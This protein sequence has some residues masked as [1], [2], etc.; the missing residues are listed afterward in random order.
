MTKLT[1]SIYYFFK[2]NRLVFWATLILSTLFFVYFGTK[3]KYEEDV[4]KL[5]PSTK[6]KDNT[7][8][9]VFENLKVK[10]KLFIIFKPTTDT[11]DV[12]RVSA[13]IDTFMNRLLVNPICTEML[14]ESLYRV[15]ADLLKNA[16]GE[17]Y[18]QLPIFIDSSDYRV[19]DS[20]TTKEAI[21]QQMHFN[22]CS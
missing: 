19:I 1:T 13:S 14:D 11:A 15:D 16:I 7:K 8:E 10:D 5:L 4:T 3:I 18:N 6:D 22:F 20:L 17:L 9:V 12:S 21:S 2:K